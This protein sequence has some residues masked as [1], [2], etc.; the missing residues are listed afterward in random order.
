[1]A[2]VPLSPAAI[3]IEQLVKGAVSAAYFLRDQLRGRISNRARLFDDADTVW[4]RFQYWG[5]LL[6][7]L[8]RRCP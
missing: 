5:K 4:K 8:P 6:A 3:R 2:I 1:L 7:S